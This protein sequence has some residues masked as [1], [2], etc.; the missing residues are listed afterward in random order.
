MRTRGTLLTTA[1]VGLLSVTSA[2]A[3][4]PPLFQATVGRS[5]PEAPAAGD[6]LGT[7][8]AVAGTRVLVGAPKV[9]N[10]SV[11][12]SG[13]VYLYDATGLPQGALRQPTP[14]TDGRFGAAVAGD[15]ARLFVGAPGD[16]TGANRA[17]AVYVYDGHTLG[18]LYMLQAPER[19]A[20]AE[21]GTTLAMLGDDVLV[22]APGDDAGGVANVGVVYRFDGPT[23][24][25]AGTYHS[26]EPGSDDRFGLA[27]ATIDGTRV[28]IG[29]PGRGG[30]GMSEAGAAYLF[31]AGGAHQHTFRSPLARTQGHFGAAVGGFGSRVLVGAP[32]EGD[33]VGAG[34]VYVF[35]VG[36]AAV[37]TLK[38]SPAVQAAHFGA[39]I[40]VRGTTFLVTAPG[41]DLDVADQAGAFHVFDGATNGF[42]GRFGNPAPANDDQF[43]G[44]NDLQFGWRGAIA[45]AGGVVVV[46][47]QLDDRGGQ[48]DAGSATIYALPLP[49]NN[50]QTCS[51]AEECQDADLCNGTEEC[52]G[53]LCAEGSSLE[54][55][56]GDAC[57]T[58]TCEAATG[59]VHT[60]P[61]VIETLD[62]RMAALDHALGQNVGTFRGPL[63]AKLVRTLKKADQ[64]LKAAHGTSARRAGRMLGRLA[65]TLGT[66]GRVAQK[67][68]DRGRI[69]P[70]VGKTLQRLAGA[71]GRLVPAVKAAL[72]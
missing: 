16:S 30:P 51:V 23:Q 9:D 13:A 67:A 33:A 26:P 19:H 70:G 38:E 20:N 28:L 40:A 62:C 10:G 29:A 58:D 7:A 69:D 18:Y 44:A 42:V 71:A 1:V 45:A 14:Q 6:E 36:G 2:W 65:R 50:G 41:D 61:A 39:G 5:S 43:G 49:P 25:L 31:A 37:T 11:T 72:S 47:A 21:F 17:G 53:G 52:V 12:R 66:F 8:V 60:E 46:G 15:G 3:V 35:D 27:L 63:A 64:Q 22:G 34:A 4:D 48:D 55:D 68:I 24:A 59:C 32:Y 57:T 56:D 54:C